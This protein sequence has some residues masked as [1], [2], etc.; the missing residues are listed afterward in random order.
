M[1]LLK[2][3]AILAAV[4][5]ISATA[6]AQSTVPPGEPATRGEVRQDLINVENQGYRPGDG[7]RTN[8]PANAQAAESR[9]SG[10]QGQSDGYGGV[11]YGTTST[12]VAQPMP[13][14]NDGTKGVYFGR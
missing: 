5:G 13:R 9:A 7:D 8:Y 3:A 14:P 4:M 10:Q 2:Q 12:G 6:I 11:K 1:K